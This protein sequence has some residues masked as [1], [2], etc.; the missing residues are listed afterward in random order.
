MKA[1][2]WIVVALAMGASQAHSQ[3]TPVAGA[4]E[5]LP[6]RAKAEAGAN[7]L[8]VMFIGVSTMLFDDGETAIMT[9]GYFTRAPRASMES[10]RP[11][12]ERITRALQRAGVKS[13]AAV[14]PVH[15]HFDHALDSPVV[16]Q[17]TNA[18]LVGS[19]STANIARG[20]GMPE[21]RIRVVRDG[22]TV[23]F[24]RFNVTFVVS[25]HFPNNYAMGEITAPL[26]APAKASDFKVGDAYALFIEHDGRTILV[27]GSA[28]FVP[29]GLPGRRADV[30]YLGIGGLGT[31]DAAY[32]DAYW[33]EMV[34]KTGA[35]RVVPIH[36]DDFFKPMDD[37]LVPNDG[38]DA[39]MQFL[40]ERG[41]KEGVEIRLPPVWTWT[42]PLAGGADRTAG[43]PRAMR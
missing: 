36:W 30:V 42:E 4:Y 27:Q 38:F 12:N 3:G 13:L 11:D 15:S 23:K 6:A 33:E 9:D 26:S 24:G 37:G 18:L 5:T 2:S 21:D 29:G 20:Y 17:R 25:A 34:R 31:R 10:V 16:A 35:R 14:I 1:F 22:E 39:A 43:A 28:G 41:R 19:R 8:T 7:K 40:L 32:R